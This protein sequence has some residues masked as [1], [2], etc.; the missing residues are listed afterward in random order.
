MFIPIWNRIVFMNTQLDNIS[1]DVIRYKIIPLLCP[2]SL[3]ILGTIS[4]SWKTYIYNY[5]K[6]YITEKTVLYDNI[7]S[8]KEPIYTIVLMEWVKK[9]EYVQLIDNKFAK[10]TC[11]SC[12]NY[13]KNRIKTYIESINTDT[14]MHCD[15]IKPIHIKPG[16]CWCGGIDGHLLHLHCNKCNRSW[17]FEDKYECIGDEKCY[18][19]SNCSY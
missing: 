3:L 18:W 4:T 12:G 17:S 6:S 1:N 16:C 11:I 15:C 19:C 5:F 10:I 7:L 14:C 13:S 9:K 8:Y 2:T